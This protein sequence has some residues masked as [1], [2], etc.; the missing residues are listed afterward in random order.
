M[1]VNFDNEEN[2]YGKLENIEVEGVEKWIIS[3]Q[4]PWFD[5]TNGEKRVVSVFLIIT[6]WAASCFDESQ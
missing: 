2:Q 5:L 6:T 3:R 1:F 4:R